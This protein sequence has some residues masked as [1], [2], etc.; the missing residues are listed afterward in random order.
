MAMIFS[1]AKELATPFITKRNALEYRK[2]NDMALWIEENIM[3]P[4]GI[5]ASICTSFGEIVC[6]W[7]ELELEKLLEDEAA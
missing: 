2:Q 7:I 3:D 6:E 4:A 1:E 5:H